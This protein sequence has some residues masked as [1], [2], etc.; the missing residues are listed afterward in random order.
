MD[1]PELIAAVRSGAT[2][3]HNRNSN[4][5]HGEAKSPPSKRHSNVP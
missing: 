3:F 4:G 1:C 5:T 2:V